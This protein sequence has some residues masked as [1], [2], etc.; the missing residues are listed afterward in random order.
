M[1]S[2]RISLII[3][4]IVT[5]LIFIRYI[6]LGITWKSLFLR[7]TLIFIINYLIIRVFYGLTKK[8]IRES[9][10]Q[11]KKNIRHKNIEPYSPEKIN[12]EENKGRIIVP[13]SN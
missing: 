13:K 5:F 1:L 10:N 4:I 2:F 3:D 6:Y 9:K 8:V 11:P 12:K 7:I